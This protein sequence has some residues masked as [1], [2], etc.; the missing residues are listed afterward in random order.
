MAM[1]FIPFGDSHSYFWGRQRKY[2]GESQDEDVPCMAW[3]GP[4]KA[5]GVYCATEN[6]TKEKLSQLRQILQEPEII[7]V[8]CF[9]EIDVRVNCAR[10]FLFTG[11]ENIVSDLVDNYLA[12]ISLITPGRICIWGPPPSAPDNGLFSVDLPAYGSNQ[13]RNYLTHV[14]NRRVIETINRYPNLFFMTIFYD[15]IDSELCTNN[16][17]LHDGCHMNDELQP[18]AKQALLQA[19]SAG[20]KVVMNTE[21]FFKVKKFKRVF[22]RVSEDKNT[23]YLNFYKSMKATIPEYYSYKPID[24]QNNNTVVSAL[25]SI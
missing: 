11:S 12:S 23:P 21:K 15:L 14:F 3:L 18:L 5:F 13:T 9:G 6:K 20:N 1:K 17:A 7:P 16:L 2:P 19:I 24:F 10:N 22:K 4:A 8:A 25:E